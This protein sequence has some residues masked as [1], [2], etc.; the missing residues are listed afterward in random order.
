MVSTNQ[1]HF[2]DLGSERHLYG[3]SAVVAQ[4]SFRWETSGEV[5]KCRLFSQADFFNGLNFAT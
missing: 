2:L 3:I 5:A 1:T 4:M